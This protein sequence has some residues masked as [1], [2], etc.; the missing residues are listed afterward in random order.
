MQEVFA[1]E[2]LYDL[3]ATQAAIRAGYSFKTAR[4]IGSENLTKPDIQEVI[5]INM[6]ARAMRTEV[7][8]DDVIRGLAS[9]AFFDISDIVVI[10]S[11]GV[12]IRPLDEVPK[13]RLAGIKLLSLTENSFKIASYN[14]IHALQ[15]LGQHLGI[16]KR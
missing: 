8:I 13:E 15:L 11:R 5:Q 4:A 10:D 14:K 12:R 7:S 9:I 2:Y 3:N 1:R 6:A 16:F